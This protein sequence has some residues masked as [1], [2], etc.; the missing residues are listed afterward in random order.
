MAVVVFAILADALVL[1]L[2]RRSN[3]SSTNIT[4][5]AGG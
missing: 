5:N 2:K 3:M 4:N 1:F